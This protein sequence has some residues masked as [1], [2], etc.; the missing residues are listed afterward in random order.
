MLLGHIDI[1]ITT[2]IYT[3][4]MPDKKVGVVYRLS[5]LFALYHDLH[6][7]CDITHN[8]IKIY[9]LFLDIPDYS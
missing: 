8:S 3:H 4:V 1:S 5:D 9:T 2:A 7:V 6:H